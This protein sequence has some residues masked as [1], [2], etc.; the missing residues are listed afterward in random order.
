MDVSPLGIARLTDGAADDPLPGHRLS[1]GAVLQVAPIGEAG[2]L[3]GDGGATA[4]DGPGLP[5]GSVPRRDHR[6]AAGLPP[7]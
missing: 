7:G 1:V 4:D 3:Q 6:L 5:W 2:L